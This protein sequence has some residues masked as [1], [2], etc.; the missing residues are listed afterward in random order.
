MQATGKSAE[1]GYTGS[2]GT[3]ESLRNTLTDMGSQPEIQKE[4]PIAKKRKGEAE[5]LLADRI[6]RPTRRAMAQQ[7]EVG[8]PAIYLSYLSG[9]YSQVSCLR[10]GL[11]IGQSYDYVI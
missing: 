1:S 3:S 9:T 5:K 7:K 2:T 10:F 11:N 4:K 6:A 8:F